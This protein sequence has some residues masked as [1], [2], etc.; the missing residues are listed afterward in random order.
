MRVSFFYRKAVEAADGDEDLVDESHFRYPGPVPQSRE[1][2]LVMLADGSEAATRA[3]RPSTAEE[4]EEV[5]TQIFEH[6]IKEGQMDE[7][8]ITLEELEIVKQT[9][10]ELLRGA[11]HPRVSYP[12]PE[13]DQEENSENNT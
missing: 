13:R 5:V 3:R 7:C 2:L 8:P 11:F 12:A 4:L 6:R 10:I 1:T 9:Y